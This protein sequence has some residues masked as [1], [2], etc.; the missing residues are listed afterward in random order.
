MNPFRL[1]F[2]RG[3]RDPAMPDVTGRGRPRSREAGVEL[4]EFALV[5]P[6]LL[7]V[8]LGV[9][10]FGFLFQRW[11]ALTNATREG[12]RVATLPGYATVDVEDRVVNYLAAGGVPPRATLP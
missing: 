5:F 3:R 9:A 11:E 10:D 8:V 2:R 12:A 4:I 7:L 6:L 1:A